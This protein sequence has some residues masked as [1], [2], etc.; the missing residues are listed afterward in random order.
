M[1]DSHKKLHHCLDANVFQ[2]TATMI[3]TMPIDQHHPLINNFS[4]T[5]V[6]LL[7]K[8]SNCLCIKE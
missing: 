7:K 6:I 3:L 4:E 8:K 5:N 2:S 1:Q